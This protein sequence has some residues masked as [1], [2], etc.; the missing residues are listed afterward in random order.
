[1]AALHGVETAIRTHIARGDDLNARDN[2]GLTPLMLAAQK[3]K[4]G[5]CRLL[6]EAG[7]DPTLVNFVGQNALTIANTSNSID[8][9]V[10]IQQSTTRN[11]GF[12]DGTP[13]PEEAVVAWEEQRS[14]AKPDQEGSSIERPVSSSDRKVPR[15]SV[16]LRI[17]EVQSTAAGPAK[18]P[19]VEIFPP[20]EETAAAAP[21]P[22]PQDFDLSTL[23]LG[24]GL[25]AFENIAWEADVELPVPPNDPTLEIVAVDIHEQIA[26]HDPIDTSSDWSELD[27]DLPTTAAPFLSEEDAEAR[28]DLRLVLLRAIREGSVPLDSVQAVTEVPNKEGE[29]VGEQV[30]HCIINDLGADVDDRI[31]HLATLGLNQVHV[32]PD[33]SPE[34]DELVSAAIASMTAVISNANAPLSLYL[35]AAQRIPLIKAEQE[36]ALSKAMETAVDQALDALARWPRGIQQ[37]LND[38]QGVQSRQ[39][40]LSTIYET[41]SETDLDESLGDFDT[42]ATL[43]NLEPEPTGREDDWDIDA[44]LMPATASLTTFAVS[45]E[46]LAALSVGTAPSGPSWKV[47]RD[48]VASLSLSRRYLLELSGIAT[49]DSSDAGKSFARSVR[50]YCDARASMATANLK[51]V[52]SLAKKYLYSGIPIDDL[53]QE[54]NLGLLRAVDKFDWR[55]GFKFSTYATWWIRQSVSR[56]V[57]DFSRTIRVPVHFHVAAQRVHREYRAQEQILGSPPSPAQLS[58]VLGVSTVQVQRMLNAFL[59]PIPIDESFSDEQ[60]AP[61]RKQDFATPDPFD[62]CD[63]KQMAV[64]VR[65]AVSVLPEKEGQIIRLRF[66]FDS[67]ESLTLEEVGQLFA[68]RATASARSNPRL[69]HAF[70]IPAGPPH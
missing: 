43:D 46:K 26:S 57:A 66:G 24:E 68:E 7:A 64:T 67:G 17:G 38:A 18:V 33:E 30:L 47:V 22:I 42:L 50:A 1:M 39:R 56:F 41:P 61:H 3:N 58:E 25:S 20:S 40:A 28:A 69:W 55:K 13:D 5:A 27:F 29:Q 51:L 19:E 15:P 62:V 49:S 9:A 59:E 60:I 21:T 70:D 10:V 23:F 34:E 63:T 12:D 14:P 16:G 31:E 45:A 4:A 48:V 36:M 11:L 8:A 53:V 52:F 37:V 32:D 54:G 6:L 65:K 2:N 44:I 35:K